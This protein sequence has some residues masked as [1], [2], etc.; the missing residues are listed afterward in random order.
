MSCEL[1]KTAEDGNLTWILD[2]TLSIV[3]LLSTSNV[4]V[5][6]VS[7]FTKICIAER[8]GTLGWYGSSEVLTESRALAEI[9]RAFPEIPTK[10]GH[11]LLRLFRTDV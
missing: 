8:Y 2:L 1:L 5:F 4:I 9:Q 10:T 11:R 7:V 6:P 3:S